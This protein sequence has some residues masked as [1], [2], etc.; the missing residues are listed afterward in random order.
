MKS[1]GLMDP[2]RARG[3]DQLWAKEKVRGRAGGVQARGAGYLAAPMKAFGMSKE[4]GLQVAAQA[5]PDAF[6]CLGKDCLCWSPSYVCCPALLHPLPDPGTLAG[7]LMPGK[8]QMCSLCSRLL[9]FYDCDPRELP[10]LRTELGPLQPASPIQAQGI[11]SSAGF[12][13]GLLSLLC[14]SPSSALP[15]TQE[16]GPRPQPGSVSDVLTRSWEFG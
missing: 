9:S 15:P 14:D 5:P 13:Q 2:P 4:E 10:A 16:P 1:L 12:A 3:I 8:P 7:Q 11:H 6:S